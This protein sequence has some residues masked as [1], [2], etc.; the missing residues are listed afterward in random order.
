MTKNS[1]VV[2]YDE[3]SASRYYVV[4]VRR[5]VQGRFSLAVL[6]I[7][8][9]SI[10]HQERH[11]PVLVALCSPVERRIVPLVEGIDASPFGYVVVNHSKPSFICRLKDRVGRS[12]HTIGKTPHTVDTS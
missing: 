10:L 6:R 9:D 5:P 8:I 3:E 11:D 1:I 7:D 2:S 4:R 12:E